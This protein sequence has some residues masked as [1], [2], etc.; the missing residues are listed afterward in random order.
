MAC[1]TAAWI[2]LRMRTFS[3]GHSISAL[4]YTSDVIL[5][6]QRTWPD[7][8]ETLRYYL[9]LFSWVCVWNGGGWGG[10]AA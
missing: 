10:A 2:S 9:L 3:I 8:T 1:W 4:I 5:G 6:H 7:S